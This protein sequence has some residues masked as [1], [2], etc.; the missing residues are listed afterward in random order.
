MFL[1]EV[2]APSH[3]HHARRCR[4]SVCRNQHRHAVLEGAFR[5]AFP[6]VKEDSLVVAGNLRVVNEKAGIPVAQ[7]AVARPVRTANEHALAIAQRETTGLAVVA[8]SL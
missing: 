3:L 8:R 4:L 1:A 7:H 6:V 2:V 5:S